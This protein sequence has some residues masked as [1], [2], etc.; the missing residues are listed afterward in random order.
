MS[1]LAFEEKICF[2]QGRRGVSI[3]LRVRL[4]WHRRLIDLSFSVLMTHGKFMSKKKVELDE[5]EAHIQ[6]SKF[7]LSIR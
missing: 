2:V 5:L 1:F 6:L 3:P 7:Y 4:S